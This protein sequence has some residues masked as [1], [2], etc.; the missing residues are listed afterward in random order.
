[1]LAFAP[2]QGFIWGM[3]VKREGPASHADKPIVDDFPFPTEKPM[4]QE[5][6]RIMAGL[7]RTE[8]E[9]VP[10]TQPFGIDPLE[11][12]PGLHPFASLA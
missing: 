4:A 1:M 12:T 3:S 2:F 5:L 8:R 9:A 7:Y 6:V 10:F 11:V